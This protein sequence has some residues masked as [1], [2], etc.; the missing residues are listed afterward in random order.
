MN[1]NP[2]L[3]PAAR[4][5]RT[6]IIARPSTLFTRTRPYRALTRRTP[7][8]D[9]YGDAAHLI[10]RLRDEA[11]ADADRL[12][13]AVAQSLPRAILREMD[14]N[15]EEVADLLIRSRPHRPVYAD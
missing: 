8:I 14:L 5:L 4:R 9:P 12:L 3:T 13:T 10:A 1:P 15:S 2:A 6:E 7:A 11:P